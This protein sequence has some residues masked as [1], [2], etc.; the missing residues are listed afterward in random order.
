MW[1][2]RSHSPAMFMIKLHILLLFDTAQLI[3]SLTFTL[4]FRQVVS[5]ITVLAIL[6]PRMSLELIT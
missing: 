2:I 5:N 4:S 3:C 6:G 1:L